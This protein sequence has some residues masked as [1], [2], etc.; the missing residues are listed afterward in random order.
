M[1]ILSPYFEKVEVQIA[2]DDRWYEWVKLDGAEAA[3]VIAVCKGAFGDR[4]WKRITEDLVGV[5]TLMGHEPAAEVRLTLRV[6]ETGE[7]VERRG[8]SM[9]GENRRRVKRVQRDAAW[10]RCRARDADGVGATLAPAAW[11]AD[12]DQLRQLLEHCFSYLTL[13]QQG[14]EAVLAA[15][16]KRL[17]KTEGKDDVTA[18]KFAL[19]VQEG[20]A[21]FGDAHAGVRGF[22][23][24]R[25]PG[26]LPFLVEQSG[27]RFVAVRGD[28][29]GFVEE[30]FPYLQ[31]LDSEPVETWVQ[32][33]ARLVPQGSPQ[34]VRRRAVRD[35]RYLQSL[36][37]LRDKPASDSFETVFANEAGKT[38]KRTLPVRRR[39]AIY[40]T[41]PRKDHGILAGNI[42]YLRLDEMSDEPTFLDG[43]DRAMDR[44]RKTRGLVIDV[45][46][47]RGGSRDP[48]RRL[49]P[50]FLKQGEARV[51]NIA[52]LRLPEGAD[53]HRAEGYLQDRGM[54]PAHWRGWSR[55]ARKAITRAAERFRPAWKPP[56]KQF[57]DWHYLVLEK[58]D[59]EKAYHY[60]KSVV[61][62]IDSDCFS[63]TDIFVGAFRDWRGVTVMGQ[64]TA[65]GSG[66]SRGYVLRN[67]G[68]QVRLSSMASFLP[69]GKTYDGNGI[70]P[71]VAVEPQPTDFIGQGDA[72][73]AAALK[74]LLR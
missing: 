69:N 58:G 7:K 37:G 67:S 52:A 16:R 63:A 46:G 64:P 23:A 43:L 10:P 18:T 34:L 50:Y 22:S 56:A 26:Y 68:L 40:G 2:G 4:W 24:A 62:L 41:W 35:L 30:G 15:M 59:N 61:V 65:G 29:R 32:A 57:S 71:D 38:R 17:G 51:G 44:F 42:G 48:L 60:D 33:A 14:T 55:A 49:F 31:S 11:Q 12:L 6:A 19:V 47:N 20:L 8:V 72:M 45:R 21:R 13:R 25:T 73:L 53:P 36:R 9:T 28:R 74:R 1:S 3:Q 70:Q 39:R 27:Q 5:L 66:R 54:H